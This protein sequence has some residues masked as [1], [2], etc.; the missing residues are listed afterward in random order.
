MSKKKKTHTAT[1]W[2]E[3]KHLRG[4]CDVLFHGRFTTSTFA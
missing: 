3:Y 1:Y 4:E 2:C